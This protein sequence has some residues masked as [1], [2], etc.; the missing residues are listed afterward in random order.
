MHLINFFSFTHHFS[1]V[2]IPAN[3]RV[4]VSS[5]SVPS[6]FIFG[7]ISVPAGS[8]LIFG[9]APILF[10][11]TGMKVDGALLIGSPTCRLRNKINITIYGAVL[12]STLSFRVFETK[13]LIF[14]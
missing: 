10:S 7:L 2:N 11:A 12:I 4:L 3:T 1:A 9:D 13:K 8:A 6:N 5:C 14:S